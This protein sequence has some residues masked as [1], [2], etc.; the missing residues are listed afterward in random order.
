MRQLILLCIFLFGCTPVVAWS[1]ESDVHYGLMK[2]LALQA[3]LSAEAA[4]TLAYHNEQL[5]DGALSAVH[6]VSV[7]ACLR[8]D[9]GMSR[10]VRDH[11]FPSDA[12]IPGLPQSR[13]VA[14]ASGAARRLVEDRLGNP[15]VG[16]VEFEL[17]LFG[18][19]FHALQDSW[20]HRGIPDI[21]R[22]LGFGICSQLLAWGHPEKRG[23][24]RQHKAD[25]TFIWPAD[26]MQMAEATYGYLLKLR[27]RHKNLAIK[28]TRAWSAVSADLKV[29]IEAD[30]KT[31][32]RNWF[33]AQGFTQ[34]DFLNGISIPDGEEMFP[35]FTFN[36][37]L[38]ATAV[39]KISVTQS[40]P[41]EVVTFYNDFL[42]SW[43]V[44]RDFS[45]AVSTFMDINAT[46][47]TL[48][49][50]DTAGDDPA[51]AVAGQLRNWLTK[52]H[53][54]FASRGHRSL[55]EPAGFPGFS[56]KG[57]KPDALAGYESLNTALFS[58]L[59]GKEAGA[60]YTVLEVP[61]SEGRQ[62]AAVF[63][64][65]HARYDSILVVSEK[66]D[67]KWR[68]VGFDWVIH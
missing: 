24:W 20:S 64:L 19:G 65:Q 53:G 36:L 38:R 21:P 12:K 54:S 46:A 35:A 16:G 66:Q 1:W 13:A 56:G 3:G 50:K 63:R 42:S 18:K 34:F 6:A 25:V 37:P 51:R 49:L 44:K 67:G 5:D 22:P 2:W 45:G 58:R 43:L 10:T 68:V 60:P 30:T 9:E 39:P 23:G 7:Y 47:K 61:K 15:N 48:F 17:E 31:K 26:A 29:F 55:M 41:A 52:D 27:G 4:E 59:A 11:H 40:A 62:Y 14:P 8:H 57:D 32:K 33:K 28:P